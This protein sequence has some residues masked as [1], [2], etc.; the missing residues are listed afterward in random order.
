VAFDAVVIGA[1][2][3]GSIA[4]R[5]LARAGARVALVDGSHPREKPCGGGVT[6]RA[7]ALVDA[8]PHGGAAIAS[9][10]FE[11]AGR[12]A[13]VDLPGHDY[14]RVFSRETFDASLVDDAVAAG[15]QWIRARALSVDRQRGR[16]TIAA[17]AH[18]IAA[19]WL[20][21][22][23]GAAG[24]VRKRVFR[25]F[26]R[27]QLSIAAGS[28]VEGLDMREIVIAFVDTPRGYLW[29]FP[30]PGHLAVGACAQADETSPRDMHAIADAWLDRYAPA[31]GCARRHYAWPIPSW[32]GAD[33]DDERA[34]GDGWMLLGDAAGLVDP[35]TREGIFFALQSGRFAA[36]ALLEASP[37][38]AYAA[39]I[40]AEVHG[41]LRR[42]ARLKAGFFRPRFTRLLIDALEQS[43]GVRRVMTDLVAGRQPYAGLKRRLLQTL[44][45]GLLLRALATNRVGGA[46]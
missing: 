28:Y 23:D 22:A 11:S 45:I 40:R 39:R 43:G 14:L 41:E 34:A 13:S 10:T 44:E 42:A 20:L 12:S 3:A 36:T 17:G 2:P 18:T 21:G 46:S 5:D 24:L 35:I 30:R 27:R 4:A 9:I 37:G 8:A 33:L 15:A 38:R 7:L 1:G 16:W 32:S 25:P 29:S 31:A 19:P 26:A 6:G